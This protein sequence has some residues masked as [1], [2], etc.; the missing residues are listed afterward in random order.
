[1]VM[2]STNFPIFDQLTSMSKTYDKKLL[3]KSS[4]ASK[5]SKLDHTDKE[6][7]YLIIKLYML[8]NE[9]KSPL[10]IPYEGHSLNND[11]NL[12][13]IEFDLE[14]FPDNLVKILN[15]FIKEIIKKK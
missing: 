11:N 9:K 4:L 8:K 2:T 5:I 14:K 13:T 7:V 15:I 3:S 10:S 6:S 1:M 12:H